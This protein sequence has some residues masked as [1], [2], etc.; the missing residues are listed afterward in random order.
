MKLD[1]DGDVEWARSVPWGYSAMTLLNAVIVPGALYVTTVADHTIQL[2]DGTTI[3]LDPK[4]QKAG[5]VLKYDLNGHLLA[6][7]RV[8]STTYPDLAE[9]DSSLWWWISSLQALKDGVLVGGHVFVNSTQPTPFFGIEFNSDLSKHDL[10]LRSHPSPGYVDS[11]LK[12]WK[13]PS[14][15]LTLVLNFITKELN[16]A[17]EGHADEILYGS[18]S[19][20][21]D[22]DNIA[23]ARY[24]PEKNVMYAYDLGIP[25]PGKCRLIDAI[26]HEND[27]FIIG[28]F[29]G[30][31]DF[32]PLPDEYEY[33]EPSGGFIFH[34]RTDGTY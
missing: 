24:D 13:L 22:D 4:D 29:Y 26:I 25:T 10:V 18:G 9:H 12:L 2:E 19:G 31:V 3:Q 23:I 33:H 20:Q 16:L 34:M 8:D 21:Y 14:N 5:L 1:K 11:P 32:N 30:P 7:Q 6:H 15:D 28:N 17:A 27:L